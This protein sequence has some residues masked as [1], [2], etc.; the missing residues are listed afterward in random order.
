MLPSIRTGR[1]PSKITNLPLLLCTIPKSGAPGCCAPQK[2][3]ATKNQQSTA[4]LLTVNTFP[5][6]S[7]FNASLNIKL[8]CLKLTAGCPSSVEKT[9][10][11]VLTEYLRTTG[12]CSAVLSGVNGGSGRIVGDSYK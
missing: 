10:P 11:A 12:P 6:K 4:A 1:P 3:N 8:L 5:P 7:V 2:L 9:C